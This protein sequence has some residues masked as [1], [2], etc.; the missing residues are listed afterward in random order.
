MYYFY[1]LLASIIS[2]SGFILNSSPIIIG[3]MLISPIFSPIIEKKPVKLIAGIVLCIVIGYIIGRIIKYRE[4]DEML[5]R[6]QYRKNLLFNIIVPL[7]SGF[8]LALALPKNNIIAIAGV[9]IAISILPPLV[10]SGI[11]LS[12]GFINKAYINGELAILNLALTTLTY[13]I[14]SYLLR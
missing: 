1:I 4:T 11:Y 13:K 9:G 3:S 5:L 10:N 2:A 14:G 6:T 8:V 7:V 12:G